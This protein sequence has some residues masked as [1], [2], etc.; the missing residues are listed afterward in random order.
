MEPII[1]RIL[2]LHSLISSGG[3]EAGQH[4][5]LVGQEGLLDALLVL[6]EECSKDYLKREENVTTF[7]NKCEFSCSHLCVLTCLNVLVCLFILIYPYLL[8]L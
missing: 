5:A 3:L 7:I 1:K 8:V 4:G 2:Q 6:Y